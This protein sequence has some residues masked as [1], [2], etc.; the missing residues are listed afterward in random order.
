MDLK[1]PVAI[2]TLAAL[3]CGCA[4]SSTPFHTTPTSGNPTPS[5]IDQSPP[6]GEIPNQYPSG[7]TADWYGQFGKCLISPNDTKFQQ[8]WSQ[9]D[10]DIERKVTLN[11]PALSG[12]KIPQSISDFVA[13]LLQIRPL[14]LGMDK[15]KDGAWMKKLYAD[16][17]FVQFT[18][19]GAFLTAVE[20]P[21]FVSLNK[22]PTFVSEYK[23][24]ASFKQAIGNLVTL[25]KEPATRTAIS[26]FEKRNLSFIA[27][28][29]L[30]SALALAGF[31]ASRGD[32]SSLLYVKDLPQPKYHLNG[33]YFGDAYASVVADAISEFLMH[34]PIVVGAS[35][36]SVTANALNHIKNPEKTTAYDDYV[37][38]AHARN[39]NGNL[40]EALF[41]K[42]YEIT[43]D[44]ISAIDG[45]ARTFWGEAR[46]CADQGLAQF[47]L[48][49]DVIVNRTMAVL[50]AKD[51]QGIVDRDNSQVSGHD[52]Q[53]L[54][55]ADGNALL[56]PF[57]SNHFQGLSDF[58]IAGSPLPPIVQVVSKPEQFSVWNSYL[59]GYKTLS[60][61]STHVPKGIP[62]ITIKFRTAEPAVDQSALVHVL[63]PQISQNVSTAKSELGWPNASNFSSD[64]DQIWKRAVDL[65]SLAVLD[66][67]RY[68]EVFQIF[69]KATAPIMY[70][71]HGVDLSFAVRQ[72]MKGEIYADPTG[73]KAITIPL[74]PSSG[75]G[76]CALL[77]VFSG[78][79]GTVYGVD[80]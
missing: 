37:V 76:S 14:L 15:I 2:A 71:T 48:I 8:L 16:P 36:D 6:S 22:D 23:G 68:K 28:E 53:V 62:N 27:P 60:Q 69:P 13:A 72:T 40:N 35:V 26:Y 52:V 70:Y 18:S 64:A 19:S 11:I 67:P 34:N 29:G 59:I 46:S 31:F 58:G 43:P 24:E 3:L 65:A 20:N 45:V 33:N 79:P 10:L 47:E 9:Y 51:E 77:R 32:L 78:L 80:P 50:N 41:G 55:G 5:G 4:R 57:S 17:S 21:A 54:L 42:S 73:G 56:A 7:F 49:G 12:F 1:K 30:A 63:C 38:T 75:G 66:Q 61:L 39:T 44:Q 25:I 74:L